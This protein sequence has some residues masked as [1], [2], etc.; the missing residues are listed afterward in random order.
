[1]NE[2]KTKVLK[3]VSVV[4][5]IVISIALALSLIALTVL[6]VGREYFTSDEFNSMVD[7]TDLATMKFVHNGEKI[8]LE[9]YVKKYVTE[10]IEEHIKN[11]PLSNFTN[12]LY[13]FAD[14]ITDFAVDKAL[15]SEYVNSVVKTEIHSMLDYFLYSDVDEAK[16]RI[17]DGIT[18][19][20]N[21]KL[22]PENAPTFEERVSAEV[23][24]AVFKYIE[25]E[26]GMSCDEIIVLISEK[27]VSD[28]KIISVV[29]FVLLVLVSIPKFPSIFFFLDFVFVG[30]K[31]HL[32]SIVVD[33]KE[34]FAG[35]E[36][37]ISYQFLKPLTDVLRSYADR[38]Y[39]IG[40]IFSGL[41]VI[42][43]IAM[44]FIKKKKRK[45]V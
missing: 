40:M 25:E 13:P 45:S 35:N 2:K 1:M 9:K 19:E 5:S 11:N 7:S 36:D 23:K 28:L 27:T 20:N 6:S 26:S 12:F 17:K 33:I 16:Q 22:N 31:G 24:I 42:S 15:S 41:F 43:L 8:T 21:V 3:I 38:A 4:L 39:D 34:H 37:L 10:N 44:Y 30:Y 18:L 32:Y 14:S 29:L